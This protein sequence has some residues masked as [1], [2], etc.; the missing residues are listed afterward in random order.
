MTFTRLKDRVWRFFDWSARVGMSLPGPFARASFEGFGVILWTAYALPFVPVRRSFK[1][2]SHQCKD[3]S[4]IRLFVAYVR[5]FTLMLYRVEQIRQAQTDQIGTLLHIPERDRFDAIV[6]SGGAIFIMPHAHGSIP[7]AEALGQIHPLLLFVR[8]T[9]DE[10]RAAWQREYYKKM[11]CAVVDVRRADD[12]VASRTMLSALREGSIILGGGDFIKPAP[13]LIDNPAEDVVRVTA[14]G[15]PVG[16]MRWPARFAAKV[17]V[18]IVPVNIEQT[19]TRLIL[20]MG[21]E[22]IPGEIVPTTQKWMDGMVELIN[23]LPTNWVFCLDRHW[24]RVLENASPN[25]STHPTQPKT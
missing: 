12:V 7:M 9:K 4:A 19:P 10:D 18:P 14:F 24:R 3:R 11:T 21:E 25:Y 13:E 23:Q 5:N 16:A 8:A 1:A 6:S 2:L 15:E 20:H 22:I 17:G